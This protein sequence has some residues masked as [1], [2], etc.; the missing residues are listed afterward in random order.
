MALVF[1]GAVKLGM[2]EG[3]CS[4]ILEDNWAMRRGIERIGGR[5][6]KTYRVYG[7]DLNA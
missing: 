3:E 6:Y 5:V 7:K 4:W 2:S 1:E